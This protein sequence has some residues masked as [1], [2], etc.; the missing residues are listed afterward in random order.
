MP[1]NACDALVAVAASSAIIRDVLIMIVGKVC[2]RFN[3]N[4]G[5]LGDC[6]VWV[7]VHPKDYVEHAKGDW[8]GLDLILGPLL[9]GGVFPHKPHLWNVTLI[10]FQ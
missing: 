10:T 2:F 5:V 4:G 8:I 9:I 1:L 3:F 6:S 7:G